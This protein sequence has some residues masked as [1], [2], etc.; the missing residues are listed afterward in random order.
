LYPLTTLYLWVA[1]RIAEPR[2]RT[3]KS[4][5][6][7]S[8][9]AAR[10]RG[11]ALML[12]VVFFS[13]VGVSVLIA[14]AA[15]KG[16][17]SMSIGDHLLGGRSFPAWLLY[18]LSVGEIYSI[19]TMIGLPSGLYAGGASYGIWFVGYILM[20]YPLGYF[21]AP[22]VWRSGV[23]YDAMTV[24]DVC[25]RH[26]RSRSLGIVTALALLCALIPWGQYQFIGLEVVLGALGLHISPLQSVPLA[27]VIAFVYLVVS[28]VRSPAF[29]S[30]LK[31]AFM[32]M[33]IVLVGLVALSR[34]GGTAQTFTVDREPHTMTTLS[35]SPLVFAVTTIVFQSS[36][37]YLGFSAAY[38]FTAKSERAIK[39]STVLMPLYML[40]HLF[41]FVASFYALTR[42][43]DLKDPNTV[44]MK[45]T[46][47]L[48]PPWLVGVVAAERGSP[49]SSFWPSPLCRS[50]ASSRATWCPTSGLTARRGSRTWWSPPPWC[51]PGR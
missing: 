40:M 1:W 31:D 20:A 13:V 38:L 43:P 17:R 8:F 34:A 36:T 2:Y 47:D 11:D 28:G 25:G 4:P 14:L 30:I 5:A 35:G 42:L 51:W 16:L 27:A 33:G 7:I 26:F 45:V 21:L 50:V 44:F 23:R 10:V 32:L 39:Q 3:R 41:L 6:T 48:L 12:A 18:F 9:P 29:V 49:G 37:F 22:L 19:G 46:T 15:R 24:P